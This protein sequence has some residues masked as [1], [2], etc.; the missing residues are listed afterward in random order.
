MMLSTQRLF[1]RG[2][3]VSCAKTLVATA[4]GRAVDGPEVTGTIASDDGMAVVWVRDTD[5][6]LHAAYRQDVTLRDCSTCKRPIGN[7]EPTVKDVKLAPA[8]GLCEECHRDEVKAEKRQRRE[9]AYED[10]DE[11]AGM[12]R[13]DAD[14]YA[15]GENWRGE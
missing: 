15:S 14:Y 12:S 11:Y 9:D 5:G 2:E 6:A 10:R 8:I 1:D 3:H 7:Y 4:D 13:R